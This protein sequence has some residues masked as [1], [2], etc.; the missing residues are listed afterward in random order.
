MQGAVRAQMQHSNSRRKE[1][2]FKLAFQRFVNFW[3]R[4]I[5]S[6]TWLLIFLI[7]TLADGV[8]CVLTKGSIGCLRF[9]VVLI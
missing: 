8:S 3:S 1:P 5:T 4:F 9:I 6:F 2:S 7:E